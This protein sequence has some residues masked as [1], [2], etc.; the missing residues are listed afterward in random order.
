MA[1]DLLGVLANDGFWIDGHVA[2]LGADGFALSMGQI[3]GAP[4]P[5]QKP[6]KRN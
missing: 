2:S 3:L 6:L 5:F 4:C 1:L